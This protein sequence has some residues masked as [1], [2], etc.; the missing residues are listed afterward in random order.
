M[1][2]KYHFDNTTKI[3]YFFENNK[4]QNIFFLGK[5]ILNLGTRPA[6]PVTVPESA[7][8]DAIGHNRR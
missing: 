7:V 6:D 5:K 2:K 8:P 1:D 3:I 4:I